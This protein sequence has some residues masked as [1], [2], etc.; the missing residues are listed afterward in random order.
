VLIEGRAELN[1]KR[2][3]G[4]SSGDRGREVSVEETGRVER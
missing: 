3:E 1:L 4:L 2:W